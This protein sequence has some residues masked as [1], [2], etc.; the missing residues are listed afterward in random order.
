VYSVKRGAL[1][2]VGRWTRRDQRHINLPHLVLA[3]HRPRQSHKQTTNKG[4]NPM[5]TFRETLPLGRTQLDEAQVRATGTGTCKAVCRRSLPASDAI[6]RPTHP[7]KQKPK[8]RR[9]H[10]P[11]PLRV[12]RRVVRPAVAQLLVTRGTAGACVCCFCVYAFTPFFTR[13]PPSI[14]ADHTHT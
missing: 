2:G 14:T 12:A 3:T 4:S 11:P 7:S 9:R 10:P 1:V 6:C 8:G 5:Y 13:P